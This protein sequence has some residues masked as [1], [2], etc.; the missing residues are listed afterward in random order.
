MVFDKQRHQVRTRYYNIIRSC[1][2][3]TA[4]WCAVYIR[5]F[6]YV[7]SDTRLDLRR[8]THATRVCI[9]N[10]YFIAVRAPSAVIINSVDDYRARIY[11]ALK[12]L[13]ICTVKYILSLCSYFIVRI[14]YA[15]WNWFKK[16]NR[17]LFLLYLQKSTRRYDSFSVASSKLFRSEHQYLQN[18]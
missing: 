10:A 12:T 14:K 18:L 4:V 11:F 1:A 7:W 5:P 3:L 8:C 6:A 9:N 2:S 17:L 13:E 16:N 15:N